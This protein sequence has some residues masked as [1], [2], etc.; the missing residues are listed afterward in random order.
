MKH[1][2]I[3]VIGGGAS[4]LDATIAIKRAGVESVCILERLDRVGKKFIS[5]GNGQGNLTNVNLSGEFYSSSKKDFYINAITKYGFNEISSFYEDLGVSLTQGDDGKIYPVSKQASAVLDM[6]RAYLE[7]K[8]TDIFTGFYVTDIS[9]KNGKYIIKSDSGEVISSDFVIL[10]VGG[11]AQKQFGTDGNGYE[12]CKKIGHKITPVYPSLVQIKTEL[13]KIKGLRGLKADAVLTAMDNGKN[14]KS[15]RGEVLFTEYGISGNAVFKISS[16]VAKS[17]SPEI[18]IEFIPDK[19][20]LELEGILKNRRKNLPYIG[21]EDV[22]TGLVN[23]MIGRAIVKSAKSGD[24]FDVV[25]A[26]KDFRLKV[27]GT[28]GFNYAQVTKGGVNVNEINPNTMES[29]INKNLYVTGELLDVDG[30]C[31]GYNLHWAYASAM[32]AV[33]DILTKIN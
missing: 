10:A 15:T 7:Y 17:T 14:L 32:C 33:A 3:A 18:K 4:G 29:L 9:N 20:K 24:V 13:D 6:M 1:Y 12:L 5:T 11:M 8:K 22:L 27:T 16:Y 31:G 25:N 26:T 28:L 2:K 23:K 21:K 30:E 19:D